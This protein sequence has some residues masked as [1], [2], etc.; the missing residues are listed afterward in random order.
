MSGVLGLTEVV[1]AS[2]ITAFGTVVVAVIG[3]I[4]IRIALGNRKEL[5]RTG[6]NL[7]GE[8]DTGNDHTSGQ[9][10]ARL[11]EMG[12][13]HE[14]RLDAVEV[15]AQETHQAISEHMAETRDLIDDFVRLRPRIHELTDEKEAPNG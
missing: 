9:S 8:W 13:R 15:V 10:L 7:M 3:L 6:E 11:E 2:L 1:Q 14:H 5:R 12:W 4:G